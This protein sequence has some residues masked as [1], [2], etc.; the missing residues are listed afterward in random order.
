MHCLAFQ[1][2]ILRC[3]DARFRKEKNVPSQRW[4]I[5]CQ[6]EFLWNVYPASGNLLCKEEIFYIGFSKFSDSDLLVS[7]DVLYRTFLTN[8]KNMEFSFS[9]IQGIHYSAIFLLTKK[10]QYEIFW[11]L[12]CHLWLPA[13]LHWLTVA[14]SVASNL[15]DPPPKFPQK[16]ILLQSL[17]CFPMRA[18]KFDLGNSSFLVHFG[19]FQNSNLSN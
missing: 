17:S 14:A 9:A 13:K 18:Q 16:Q 6:T 12:L 19:A 7:E 11:N 3:V 10:E 2:E 15:P 1:H 5:L 4:T 8:N